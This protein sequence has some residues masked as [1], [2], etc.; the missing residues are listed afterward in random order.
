MDQDYSKY[1]LI[2]SY[3][4]FKTEEKLIPYYE[5]IINEISSG[6]ILVEFRNHGLGYNNI[7]NRVEGIKPEEIDDIIIFR[8][9]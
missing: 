7:L 6:S 4:P 3:S 1:N 5:K 8:K 9:I 2:Y